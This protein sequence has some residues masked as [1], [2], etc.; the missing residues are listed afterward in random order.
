VF[1]GYSQIQNNFC[2]AK[3]FVVDADFKAK[4]FIQR[5]DEPSSYE[6]FGN[7]GQ[8]FRER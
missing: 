5:Y 3:N 8:F 4:D 2:N 6:N 7:F 1:A